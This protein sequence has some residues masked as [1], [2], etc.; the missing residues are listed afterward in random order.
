MGI[1]VRMSGALVL[2]V[3]FVIV[4]EFVLPGSRLSFANLGVIFSKPVV[5]QVLLLDAVDVHISD[6]R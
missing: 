5:Y 6:W 3:F 1:V 2:E 4:G